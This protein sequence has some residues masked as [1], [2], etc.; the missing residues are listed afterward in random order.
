MKRSYDLASSKLDMQWTYQ[1]GEEVAYAS[2]RNISGK[3]IECECP[4]HGIGECLLQLVHLKMFVA[5]SLPVASHSCDR[6]YSVSRGEPSCVELIV[7][8]DI[9]ED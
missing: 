6:Q 9:P 8:D 1:S 7:W 2:I 5:D 3:C 4:C